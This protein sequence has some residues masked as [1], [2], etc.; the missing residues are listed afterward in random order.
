LRLVHVTTVPETLAFLSGQCRYL[1]ARGVEVLAVSSHGEALDRFGR[2]EGIPCFG[3]PMERG[4]SPVRDLASLGRLTALLRRLR[5]T[6]VDA[7][8]PKAGL[9]GMLAA[10]LARVP[11]RIY[12]LHGLRFETARGPRREL[13]RAMERVASGLA[14][15]VL[16]VSSSV[17]KAILA[18]HLVGSEKLAVLGRGSINGVDASRF[19][20]A[21]PEE[22]RAA[23]AALGLPPDAPVVGFVGRL[24]RDKGVV[25]LWRSWLA[26]REEIPALRFILVGPPE[27]GDPLPPEIARAIAADSRV[28]STGFELDT[29]RFYRAMDVVALPTY[30]EGFPVVPLEAAAMGLPVVATLVTGCVDAVV[31]GTTG[32]LVPHRDIG[33]LTAALRRYLSDPS[34]RERHGA[35]AR[36]RAV[37]E[38]DPARLVA[39]L[40]EQYQALAAAVRPVRGPYPSDRAR[41]AQ[42]VG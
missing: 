10:R 32:T 5:P 11:V 6:I 39:A 33:A 34:L 41:P 19:R 38:F 37:R 17:A 21:T 4:I 16:A 26:L 18:E 27:Q 23:R 42:P 36:A 2:E 30:R 35:A 13:L 14:T 25:E 24:A 7:H 20:P 12:H 40:H 22:R 29:P 28:V 9:L 15:R 3:V 1:C 31:N 8:T